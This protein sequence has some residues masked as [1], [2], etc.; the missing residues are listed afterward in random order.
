MSTFYWNRIFVVICL[1]FC[2]NIGQSQTELFNKF[3]WLSDQYPNCE[4][5]LFLEYRS[6]EFS[7]IWAS[8]G[9]LFFQDG[10]LYCKDSRTLDCRSFYNL[11]D[12]KLESTCSQSN[13]ESSEE[14]NNPNDSEQEA[15]ISGF[16]TNVNG[17]PLAGVTIT[18]KDQAGK[19]YTTNT[20][21]LGFYSFNLESKNIT[22]SATFEGGNQCM[23]VFDLVKTKAYILGF[24]N[25]GEQLGSLPASVYA[26]NLSNNINKLFP[27][28][29]FIDGVSTIDLVIMTRI[30]L[31]L[32]DDENLWRFYDTSTAV[33]EDNFFKVD[34]SINLNGNGEAN[35][36][37]FQLGDLDDCQSYDLIEDFGLKFFEKNSETDGSQQ[38]FD[39][40]TPKQLSN[41][42]AIELTIQSN[43][44]HAIISSYTDVDKLNNDFNNFGKEN[45]EGELKYVWQSENIKTG[46]TFNPEE[47][48]IT[49]CLDSKTDNAAASDLVIKDVGLVTTDFEYISLRDNS[50]GI[51]F[52]GSPQQSG[53]ASDFVSKYNWAEST[54]NCDQASTISEYSSSIFNFLYVEPARILYF[55]DGTFYCED[56]KNRSC[57]ELYNL[58]TITNQ[59]TCDESGFA[60]NP[61]SDLYS[62]ANDSELEISISPNPV[63]DL[64]TVSTKKPIQTLQIFNSSGQL[65]QQIVE[66]NTGNVKLDFNGLENAM[67]IIKIE[68]AGKVLARRIIKSS[69]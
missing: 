11:N 44:E 62:F 43:P 40:V 29:S 24:F 30:L 59:W 61:I 19:S 13:T 22:L 27:L 47:T 37:G 48:L 6:G 42:N 57:L 53:L 14:S 2:C 21:E 9:R 52:D 64:L 60:Q 69:L 67:Y 28:R 31:E 10:T 12:I 66:P 17:E 55:Q 63:V 65:I 25:S 20:N 41:I 5:D 16:V 3:S 51:N 1:I 4:E 45:E 32:E 50:I 7:F 58:E 15:V 36:T 49:V 8:D 39:I 35:F 33:A 56:S 23:N 38:C 18:A 26:M 46:V 68:T 34:Q 54:L